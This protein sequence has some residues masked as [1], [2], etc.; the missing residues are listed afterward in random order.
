[1]NNRSTKKYFSIAI[2]NIGIELTSN[3]PKLIRGI[4]DRYH[5]FPICSTPHLKAHIDIVG[6]QR[7]SPLLDTGSEFS[8]DLLYFTAPGYHGDIN[9]AEGTA[10]LTLSS[11]YPVEDTDY[12]VRFL[13]ALLAFREGGLLFHAAGIVRR[14]LA[15]LF[16]GQSGSGK[17]TVSRLSPSDIVLNDDLVL[18][19]PQSDCWQVYGTPFWNPTQIRPSSKSA[20]LE[21]IFRLVQDKEVFTKVLTPSQAL[22]ELI[23]NVPVIP[24]DPIRSQTLIN[25][26]LKLQKTIP[27]YALH[28]LPDDSFWEVV[29]G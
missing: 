25:L 1:M 13:Y 18:I 9:V 24:K 26:L 4:R 17:T 2:G 28:F 21:K 11:R 20:P 15:Y 23:A 29:N 19:L 27:V 5:D 14:G 6:D 7:D 10:H 22:A 3:S 16:T 12:F 8:G